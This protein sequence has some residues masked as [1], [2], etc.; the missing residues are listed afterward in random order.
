M[1]QH[2]A[3]PHGVHAAESTV[4][5]S[6]GM[7]VSGE[8]GPRT[9]R[10]RMLMWL[11]VPVAIAFGAGGGYLAA[12]ARTPANRPP[13]A[14][15]GHSNHGAATTQDHG[16]TTAADDEHG[17]RDPAD[18]DE[19]GAAGQHQDVAGND[20]ASA[21]AAADGSTGHDADGDHASSGDQPSSGGHDE[22]SA[23]SRP[24]TA[25]L[26]AFAAV[27]AAILL[28]AA[29]LRRRRPRTARRAAVRTA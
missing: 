15:A 10:R 21:P 17:D 11:A 5:A 20:T 24:R 14:T 6:D 18:A 8:P 7:P 28:A 25:V 12:G 1:S 2:N 3:S 9:A 16:G 22:P 27:N 4:D 23:V 19:H 29:I 26:T 13:A